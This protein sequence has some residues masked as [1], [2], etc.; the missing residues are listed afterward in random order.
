MQRIPEYSSDFKKLAIKVVISIWVFIL[1]YLL[2]I[3]FSFSLIVALFISAKLLLDVPGRNLFFLSLIPL[4]I[5]ILLLIFVIKFFFRKSTFDRSMWIEITKDQEPNF[6]ELIESVADEINTGLPN[7]VYLSPNVDAMVFYDSN[8]WN[9]FFPSKENLV[10]GMGL[11][12]SINK[13]ELKAVLAHEFGHFTQRSL[14]R[15][16]LVYIWNQI[17]Y[18]MLIDEEYYH[19]LISKFN[20]GQFVWI[21]I[22]YSTFIRWILRKAYDFVSFNYGPLSIELEYHADE[23]SANLAGTVPN[24]S[25]M[26]RND[27]ANFSFEYLFD[28]YHTFHLKSIKTDNIYPQHYIVMISTAK[29]R[30]VEIKHGL[31]VIT[32]KNINK[33]NR[34]K[35]IIKDQWASHPNFTDRI[36]RFNKLNVNV[37]VSND[38]ALEYFED[39]DRLQKKLTQKLFDGWKDSKSPRSISLNEF[40][41]KFTEHLKKHI[42]DKRYN[43]FYDMRDI[44][45]FNFDKID[46]NNEELS[47]KLFSDIYTSENVDLVLNYSGLENDVKL[48]ECIDRKEIKIESFEYDS[49]KYHIKETKQ[50]LEKLREE[51]RKLFKEVNTLD[52]NIYKF[53]INVARIKGERNTYEE[54]YKFY[55]QI[56]EQDK[57]N[58]KIYLDIMKSL[59]IFTKFKSF[60][61]IKQGMDELKLNETAMKKKLEG[62]INDDFYKPL[63]TGEQ[64]RK[65]QKYLSKDWVYFNEPRFDENALELLGE[66]IYLFYSIC[67]SAPFAAM[68]DL[69][70]YQI[71]L[72]NE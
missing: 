25:S 48:I 41:E 50:L 39:K 46:E 2:T 67:S 55:F 17:I 31:P 24:I 22:G 63:I 68:K 12:N 23:I 18:K 53:F 14:K 6:F 47:F 7:R 4:F 59:Q 64:K 20:L 3:L 71:T 36:A 15:F 9:L 43:Y 66:I 10:I 13:S 57:Q 62:I 65:I 35:L 60:D 45:V 61:K 38:L 33:F 49:K 21:V 54:K 56:L 72:I 19:S 11:I 30:G 5:G 16:S 44:S 51:K 29:E 52:I 28:F 26:H 58:S 27:L 70:D 1:I 42:I 34:S 8:F 32:E 69:L 37:Q 40:Q